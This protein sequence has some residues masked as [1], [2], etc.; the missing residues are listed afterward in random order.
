MPTPRERMKIEA[1]HQMDLAA[2]RI[3]TTLA[4]FSDDKIIKIMKRVID[5][6]G[7]PFKGKKK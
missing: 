2:G 1:Q 6:Y 3:I 7:L 4:P 5:F